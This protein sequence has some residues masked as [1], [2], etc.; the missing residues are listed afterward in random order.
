MCETSTR[1]KIVRFSFHKLSLNILREVPPDRSSLREWAAKVVDNYSGVP[2]GPARQDVISK[3][4]PVSRLGGSAVT[5][6]EPN[7]EMQYKGYI[8]EARP[9]QWR[10]T[11]RWTTNINILAFSERGIGAKPFYADNTYE[12]KIEAI[13]AC[14]TFGKTYHRWTHPEPHTSRKNMKRVYPIYG[15]D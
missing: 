13:E 1:L 2:F 10:D 4:L 9:N 8:I 14:F 6:F 12:A 5:S 3:K 15:A 11:G 7:M